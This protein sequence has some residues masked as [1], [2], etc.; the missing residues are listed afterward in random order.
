MR[1]QQVQQTV[2]FYPLGPAWP[3]VAQFPLGPA[4]LGQAAPSTM[5]QEIIINAGNGFKLILNAF[6]MIRKHSK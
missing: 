5:E 4:W 6:N 2:C 1:P 3:R